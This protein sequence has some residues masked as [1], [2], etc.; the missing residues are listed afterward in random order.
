MHVNIHLLIHHFGYVG[1]FVILLLEMIGIP[2]P[3][4]TTLTLSGVEWTRGAFQ[5][6][7]LLVAASVGN[8]LGSLAAYGI[9][10]LLGRP[11]VVRWGKYVGITHERLDKANLKFQ[12]YEI[13]VV[14]FSKFIAGIRVLIPYLAGINRMSFPL[15]AIF[16]TISAVVWSVSFIILGKYIGIEWS[17]Y[18][19]T[20]HQ[21]FLPAAIVG[22][23]LIGAFYAWRIRR[24]RQRRS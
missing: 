20:L 15:F 2:F 13:A 11:I 12:N 19:Q 23:L 18:H 10:R 4:E 9:G 6:V 14:F 8:A 17:R 16:T 7:P 3:A 24:H 22:A 5:L 1:V 21:Y